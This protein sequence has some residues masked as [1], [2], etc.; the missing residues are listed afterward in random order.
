MVID[1][2]WQW[3]GDPAGGWMGNKSWNFVQIRVLVRPLTLLARVVSGPMSDI[4]E[5]LNSQAAKP[6]TNWTR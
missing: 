5:N 1:Q 4:A 2:L 6:R 3:H